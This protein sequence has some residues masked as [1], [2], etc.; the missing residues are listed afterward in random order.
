MLMAGL[1]T[2]DNIP[3][4]IAE[5]TSATMEAHFPV[6]VLSRMKPTYERSLFLS[7]ETPLS[8][9]ITSS[10]FSCSALFFVLWVFSCNI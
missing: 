5:K 10:F 4:L 3:A 6:L 9:E 2:T 8:E 1:K 7:S